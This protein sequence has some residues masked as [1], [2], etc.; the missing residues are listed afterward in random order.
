MNKQDENIV[1]SDAGNGKGKAGFKG[2]FKEFSSLY[3]RVDDGIVGDLPSGNG[4]NLGTPIQIDLGTRG[5]WNIGLN[6]TGEGFNERLMGLNRYTDPV[7]AD[8]MIIASLSKFPRLLQQDNPVVKLGVTAPYAWLKGIDTG[9]LDVEKILKKSMRGTFQVPYRNK[10]VPVRISSVKVW[11]EGLVGYAY[12]AYDKDL[13][14][15]P[16]YRN[17]NTLFLDIGRDTINSAMMNGSEAYVDTIVSEPWGVNLLYR[18]IARG[19][20]HTAGRITYDQVEG[21][22]LSG[23]LTAEQKKIVVA[24]SQE[25]IETIIRYSHT[26]EGQVHRNIDR[27]AIYGGAVKVVPEIKETIQAEFEKSVWGDEFT[28]VKGLNLLLGGVD[29]WDTDQV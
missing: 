21:L 11:A 20:D 3:A 6:N 4:K 22:I 5:K 13:K 9:G 17:S 24:K 2:S 7:W 12:F 8:L 26:V 19:L 27:L 23:Q 15:K 29:D 1:V 16:D 25:Y 18:M 28:N 14:L 10:Q